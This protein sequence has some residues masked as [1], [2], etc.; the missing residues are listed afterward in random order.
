MTRGI[1]T[2]LNRIWLV[3]EQQHKAASKL[4]HFIMCVFFYLA[5]VLLLVAHS[6]QQ[7]LGALGLLKKDGYCSTRV[8]WL[9]QHKQMPSGTNCWGLS[10]RKKL[11]CKV[12]TT[13]SHSPNRRLLIFCVII[14]LHGKTQIH[15][16]V[17]LKDEV[18]FLVPPLN[19]QWQEKVEEVISS[20]NRLE[21][22]FDANVI[23]VITFHPLVWCLTARNHV[24]LGAE[25]TTAT[26][27]DRDRQVE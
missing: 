13:R 8:V 26:D 10:L 17:I 6:S 16:N 1:I 22:P 15:S 5:R 4:L 20:K 19:W 12:E 11:F 23:V 7:L 9:Q 27:G 2:K 24:H 3:Q 21:I 25:E 18:L 14:S